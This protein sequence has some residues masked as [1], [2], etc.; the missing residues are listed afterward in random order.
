MRE[1]RW[2]GRERRE[3]R[4][5]EK[6]LPLSFFPLVFA[7]FLLLSLFFFSPFA[8]IYKIGGGACCRILVFLFLT[9]HTRQEKEEEKSIKRGSK[10]RGAPV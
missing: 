8:Q 7:S 4:K 6:P 1:R 3:K 2:R 10:E 5:K 9:H